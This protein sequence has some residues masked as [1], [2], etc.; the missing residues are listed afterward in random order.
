MV[1]TS[2]QTSA[3]KFQASGNIMSRDLKLEL[4]ACYNL[5][6][7]SHLMLNCSQLRVWFFYMRN[8][9][10]YAIVQTIYFTN[11]EEHDQL[12]EIIILLWLSFTKEC[13]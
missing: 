5:F 11:K 1:K 10:F 12:I 4:L 7:I 2:D 13:P 8:P 6:V 9:R 3:E